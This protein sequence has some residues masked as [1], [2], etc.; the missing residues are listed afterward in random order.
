MLTYL[1]LG[2]SVFQ[3]HLKGFSEGRGSRY[4]TRISLDSLVELWLDDLCL[5]SVGEEVFRNGE[6]LK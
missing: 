6:N 1:L 2:H 3:F 4:A 5:D